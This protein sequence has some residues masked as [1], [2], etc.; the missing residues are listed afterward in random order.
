MDYFADYGAILRND[1]VVNT[2]LEKAIL[3]IGSNRKYN[4]LLVPLLTGITI[5]FSFLDG[6]KY[7]CA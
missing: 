6:W 4:A 1:E 7:N 2:M 5:R 3:A